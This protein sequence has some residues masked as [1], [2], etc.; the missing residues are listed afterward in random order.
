M[1]PG[2]ASA[3][4]DGHSQPVGSPPCPEYGTRA[5]LTLSAV[6][7]S[8]VAGSSGSTSSTVDASASAK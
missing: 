4:F 1:R 2:S 5:L 3:V 7:L 8:P 6:P